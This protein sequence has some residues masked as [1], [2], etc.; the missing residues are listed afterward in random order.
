[1]PEL[2]EYEDLFI[3]SFIYIYIDWYFA[4]NA[5]PLTTTRIIRE[6]L[7]RN[8]EIMKYVIDSPLI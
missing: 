3:M 1:M 8:V 7:R 4:K 6:M 2:C 5:R